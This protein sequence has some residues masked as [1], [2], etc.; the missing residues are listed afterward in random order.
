MNGLK[1]TFSRNFKVE[2]KLLRKKQICKVIL[3]NS[4][5]SKHF[6]YKPREYTMHSDIRCKC[7]YSVIRNKCYNVRY[8]I[9]EL[10]FSWRKS[11][12]SFCN[13]S[14]AVW[15]GSESPSQPFVVLRS[16]KRA[17]YYT[18]RAMFS[19]AIVIL[20]HAGHFTNKLT[21]FKTS[22]IS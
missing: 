4:S 19:N 20:G 1:D 17:L 21:C 9:L 15:Y 7:T 16:T 13:K 22:P 10:S 11:A 5:I 12:W 14:L 18:V 2:T 3:I 8:K 6:K